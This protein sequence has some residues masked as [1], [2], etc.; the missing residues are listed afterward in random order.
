MNESLVIN[1][2]KSLKKRERCISYMELMQVYIYTGYEIIWTIRF[3]FFET[4]TQTVKLRYS[5]KSMEHETKQLFTK[6]FSITRSP[7]AVMHSA[8]S[9][10]SQKYFAAISQNEYL[11]LFSD[12]EFIKIKIKS[13]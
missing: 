9:E 1:C 6:S 12:F 11:I 2:K 7:G 3:F 8:K 10:H 5:S 4:K 13:T